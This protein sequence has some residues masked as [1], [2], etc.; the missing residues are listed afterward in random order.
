MQLNE[1]LEK[2]NCDF[3]ENWEKYIDEY[4]SIPS[5][6]YFMNALQ[7]FAD[8]ICEKQRENCADNLENGVGYTDDC[9]NAD[10]PKIDE[11]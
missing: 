11:V 7:N 3:P 6:Q 9:I 2:Y 4:A 10:Q 5:E 1:F 8:I